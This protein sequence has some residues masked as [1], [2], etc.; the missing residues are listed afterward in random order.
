MMVP[1]IGAIETL[2]SFGME[3]VSG[4]IIGLDTDTPETGRVLLDFV[5]QSQIPMLTMNLLQALPRT[6]LWDRL[7]REQRLIEN[8]DS[9]E[10]NVAFRMPYDEVLA[11][12]REC[13]RVAYEPDRAD[14]PLRAPDPRHLSQ[15]PA[16]AE[17]PAACVMAQHQARAD[18]A[19]AHLLV[20]RHQGRLPPRV[21]AV[22]VARLMRG[23]IEHL[24]R[25]DVRSPTT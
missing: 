6:P 7:K 22:R 23:E 5:E 16:A 9:R 25:C 17:Q 1:I 21:L 24:I 13:M 2:N 18:H 19:V 15:P 3:V 12:W 11:M 20:G 8:D 4:I 10:S 14:R